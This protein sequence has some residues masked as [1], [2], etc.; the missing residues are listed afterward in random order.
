MLELEWKESPYFQRNSQNVFIVY[1]KENPMNLNIKKKNFSQPKNCFIRRESLRTGFLLKKWFRSWAQRAFR[2]ST[3]RL[4]WCD[5]MEGLTDQ[6]ISLAQKRWL[7]L[8]RP[9]KRYRT[10]IKKLR[11][12]FKRRF[13]KIV[14]L[15]F[16]NVLSAKSLGLQ[17]AKRQHLRDATWNNAVNI[18][19]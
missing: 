9:K 12:K 16:N 13:V 11:F 19:T 5:L 4:L 15:D 18:Y 14:T 3:T 6:E 1:G 8:L 7:W 10:S 2:S 17:L